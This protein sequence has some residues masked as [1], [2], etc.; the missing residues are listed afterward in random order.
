M[1]RYTAALGALAEGL[2][3]AV[4]GRNVVSQCVQPVYL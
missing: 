3:R 1:M 4:K 2:R